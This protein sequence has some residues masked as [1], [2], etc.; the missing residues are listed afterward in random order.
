MKIRC[1]NVLENI[2]LVPSSSLAGYFQLKDL[3]LIDF[4]SLGEL[5]N[6]YLQRNIKKE[7]EGKKINKEILNGKNTT[8]FVITKQNTS[9]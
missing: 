1:F 7:S 6:H 3:S 5:L 2:L 4:V 9:I 8:A